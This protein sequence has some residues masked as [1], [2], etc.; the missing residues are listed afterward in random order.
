MDSVGSDSTNKAA[1]LDEAT[2]SENSDFKSHSVK[3]C[4]FLRIKSSSV[5][6]SIEKQGKQNVHVANKFKNLDKGDCESVARFR[7]YDC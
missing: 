3:P 2:N 5:K 6:K 7:D 4:K 1:S